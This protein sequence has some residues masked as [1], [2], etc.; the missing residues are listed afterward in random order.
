MAGLALTGETLRA[1]LA[2]ALLFSWWMSFHE[3]AC[4]CISVRASIPLWATYLNCY[5][6]EIGTVIGAACALGLRRHVRRLSEPRSLCALTV[7][8]AICSLGF[9]FNLEGSAFIPAVI[10][11][12]L[13][14]VAAGL[15]LVLGMG[16]IGR[17]SMRAVALVVGAAGAAFVAVDNLIAPLVMHFGGLPWAVPVQVAIVALLAWMFFLMGKNEAADTDVGAPSTRSFECFPLGS[18]LAHRMVDTEDRNGLEE[19]AETTRPRSKAG[20]RRGIPWPLVAHLFVYGAIF[21]AMHVEASTLISVYSARAIPYGIGALVAVALYGACFLRKSASM[22]IWPKVR[23]IV[24]P[25]TTASFLMLPFLDTFESFVPVALV[26]CAIVLYLLIMALGVFRVAR[27]GRLPVALVSAVALIVYET[28]F[29]IGTLL[30]HMQLNVL[31][32]D[33]LHL[34]SVSTAAFLLLVA[35]TL[36]VGDDR[37]A[38]RLWGARVSLPP[39]KLA[40]EQLRA[41][42]EVVAERCSLTPRETEILTLLAQGRK[43]TQVAEDLTISLNTA[44]T[45]SKSI[46]AKMGVHS[47]TEMLD[48]VEAVS[49]QDLPTT[50][51]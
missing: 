33:V 34:P 41:R 3:I 8:G 16:R 24:F 6:C 1:A 39:K 12:T 51:R 14:N 25:L 44:R 45:H 50:G 19:A 42:C 15:L 13:V 37:Q 43:I 36:W 9:Y 23:D 4:G 18:W 35:A 46:Y 49:E 48:A 31:S 30:C 22:L 17:L 47:Q 28:A 32:V 5:G 11:Q 20:H 21:G 38:R 10:A 7:A 2:A 40:L 26:N 29:L 27:E